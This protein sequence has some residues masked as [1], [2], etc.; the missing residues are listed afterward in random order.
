MTCHLQFLTRLHY[1]PSQHTGYFQT[2]S[3]CVHSRWEI[4]FMSTAMVAAVTPHIVNA[5]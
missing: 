5:Q 2:C 4:P 3:T 1:L